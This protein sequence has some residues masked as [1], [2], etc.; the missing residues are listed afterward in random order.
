[1]QDAT[2]RYNTVA[3][4]FDY[5]DVPD[6][7]YSVSYPPTGRHPGAV[8]EFTFSN[9][10]T[11]ATNQVL[12]PLFHQPHEQAP[13]W[14]N[15]EYDAIYCLALELLRTRTADTR[16][17]MVAAARH[18][19]EVDFVHYSDH[20]QQHRATPQ[21]SYDHTTLMSAIPSHQ[22][23]QGLY[24]YY[25][26]TGDDDALEV[27]RGICDFNLTYLE[28]DELGFVLFFNRELG[29]ALVGLVCG[30]EVTAD[31]RYLAMSQKILRK[32]EQD[33]GRTDFGGVLQ[34]T[35]TAGTLNAT[36]LG[37]GFNANTIPLGVKLYHQA[38]GNAWARDL[39]LHWVAYGMTNFNR[40]D[41]GHLLTELFPESLTYAVEL[42]GDPRYLDETLWQLRLF[43][44]G[45]LT[46]GW[47]DGMSP[48]TTKLY[49]RMYR[50][51]IFLFSALAHR[52][53]L[54]ELEAA[55]M[56]PPTPPAP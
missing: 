28:R 55:I 8:R 22:W 12:H 15:N 27:I 18:Q 16:R 4:M 19:L 21:H 50:G 10:H 26:L 6:T 44:M 24:Y 56:G 23:T 39:F 53:R 33:A 17:R 45:H 51:L 43:L 30:Y 5:G 13:V 52:G 48:L 41:H 37:L 38:T 42:T 36:G 11:F 2:Q 47:L 40:R 14:T 46:F 35:S 3:R 25:A 1:M 7:G 34:K 9:N 32:L 49:T 20:W 31:E 29:W 54:P